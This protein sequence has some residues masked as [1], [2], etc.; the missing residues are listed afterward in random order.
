MKKINLE[1]D[2]W[3]ILIKRKYTKGCKL[4]IDGIELP[5][6]CNCV[7]DISTF[8][9]FF[10]IGKFFIFILL[11]ENKGLKILYNVRHLSAHPFD[12][13]QDKL[14]RIINIQK[15]FYLEGISFNCEE[16]IFS[17]YITD[18]EKGLKKEFYA[19]ITDVDIDFRRMSE[20]IDL[21]K[22][23]PKMLKI[24][25]EKLKIS[26]WANRVESYKRRNYV[27]TNRGEIKLVDIDPKYYFR[28]PVSIN[29]DLKKEIIEKSQFP[30]KRR[31]YQYQ[32][33]KEE[34]LLGIRDM[35]HRYSILDFP[36][37]FKGKKVL[38]IGCNFGMACILAAQRESKLCVGID[39]CK[40]TVEV[41]QK[42]LAVKKYKDIKMIVYNV[43]DGLDTLISLIGPDKFDYVFAL[44]IWKHVDKVKLYDIINYYCKEKCWFE[45][46]SRQSQSFFEK[47]L[48]ENLKFSQIKFLG[49]TIDRGIRPNF[50]LF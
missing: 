16:E 37:S 21:K 29:K 42:Y 32:S 19:Y 20:N 41:S 23:V 43:N 27:I 26:R 50:L 24:E 46:H 28:Y 12:S 5:Q 49:N 47:E 44:S 36:S 40:E 35:E 1:I 6:L 25:W 33:M 45:G 15:M 34:G 4:F 30:Y 3:D 11:R 2:N 39:F 8:T 9:R 18:K 13:P 22:I 48:S 7:N 14:A 17:V 38:D 31:K 10:E